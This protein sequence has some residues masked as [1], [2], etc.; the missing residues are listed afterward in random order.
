M[1]GILRSKPIPFKYI[2]DK[3]I[4]EIFEKVNKTNAPFAFQIPQKW[5]PY[6]KRYTSRTYHQLELV[7]GTLVG[8]RDF[9]KRPGYYTSHIT[10]EKSGWQNYFNARILNQDSSEVDL[11]AEKGFR[12]SSIATEVNSEGTQIRIR[13]ISYDDTLLESIMDV[14]PWVIRDIELI[15]RNIAYV[16]RSM[17]WGVLHGKWSNK[18]FDVL[19]EMINPGFYR[20][21]S[22]TQ[23]W[24]RQ[25]L[26]SIFP[27]LPETNQYA[28]VYESLEKAIKRFKDFPI[29]SKRPKLS[30]TTGKTVSYIDGYSGIRDF[31]MLSHLAKW[32][33]E[34]RDFEKFRGNSFKSALMGGQLQDTHP[35]LDATLRRYCFH[36]GISD[37]NW[38][39]TK[40][41]SFLDICLR[42]LDLDPASTTSHCAWI[43]IHRALRQYEQG[44]IPMFDNARAG[45]QLAALNTFCSGAMTEKEL[46]RDSNQNY[47]KLRV[48]H[49]FKTVI[50]PKLTAML[51]SSN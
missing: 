48:H 7:D 30:S 4:L 37:W 50:K 32:F 15:S 43:N 18:Y 40:N 19:T 11:L 3:N 47:T 5:A 41:V 36:V 44:L 16:L 27:T 14:D 42:F 49:L 51:N 24:L 21:H 33:D 31:K 2:V 22:S 25:D 8:T 38:N 12:L 46:D 39:K 29:E 26:I 35:E 28:D 1:S 20:N 6:V 17:A 34:H 23:R 13:I 10:L 9:K 45:E